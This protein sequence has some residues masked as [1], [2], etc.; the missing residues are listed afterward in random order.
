MTNGI[1]WR[2]APRC[3]GAEGD[4]CAPLTAAAR[5][6]ARGGRRSKLIA[7]EAEKWANVITFCGHEARLIQG[8]SAQRFRVWQTGHG[9]MSPPHAP[10]VGPL[11]SPIRTTCGALDLTNAAIASGSDATTPSR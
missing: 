2:S 4:E 9:G 5:F 10:H 1:G 6:M 11:S 7:D 8:T 3:W